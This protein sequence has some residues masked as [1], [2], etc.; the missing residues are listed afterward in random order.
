MG[1]VVLT[2]RLLARSQCRADADTLSPFAVHALRRNARFY[3]PGYH[4][5]VEGSIC[6]RR[7]TIPKV[8]GAIEAQI[9]SWTPASGGTSKLA[10][11]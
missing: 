4:T 6:S 3:T 2:T 10:R 1:V 8:R 5:A 11:E 9:K 7:P